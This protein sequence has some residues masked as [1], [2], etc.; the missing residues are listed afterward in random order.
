MMN[1]FRHHALAVTV[2]TVLL[3]TQAAT[4][5]QDLSS[6][7]WEKRII[8][9]EAESAQDPSYQRQAAALMAEFN[10]LLERDLVVLTTFHDSPFSITLIGKDGER[11]LTRN[12]PVPVKDLFGLIDSMPM[13]QA[14]MDRENH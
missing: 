9:I 12:K 10:G 6:Y 13:R 11:K 1:S 7:R 14:E 8:T 3:A 2:S 4:M 5:D